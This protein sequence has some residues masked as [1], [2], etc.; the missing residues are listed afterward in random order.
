MQPGTVVNVSVSRP[1]LVRSGSPQGSLVSLSMI[2]WDPVHPQQVCRWPRA[3]QCIW[4]KRR[5]GFHDFPCAGHCQCK[6]LVDTKL[7]NS[8]TPAM[9]SD[10]AEQVLLNTHSLWTTAHHLIGGLAPQQGVPTQSKTEDL[11]VLCKVSFGNINV[12]TRYYYINYLSHEYRTQHFSVAP[13]NLQ[14]GNKQK[15]VG[16]R[17]PELTFIMLVSYRLRLHHTSVIICRC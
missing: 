16:G 11:P 3:E 1:S 4:H 17:V 6:V 10:K 8:M 9:A 15:A 12:G 7:H 2:W 14:K 13:L 5:R